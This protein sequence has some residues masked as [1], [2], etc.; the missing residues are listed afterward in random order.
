MRDK[1]KTIKISPNKLEDL[2]WMSYRYCIGRRTAAASMH[3]GTIADLIFNNLD[4]FNKER[5]E[6]IAEDIRRSIL[7]VIKWNKHIK[8]EDHYSVDNW[9]WDFYSALLLASQEC[10]YPR[11][12]IYHVDIASRN[13]TWYRDD[14]S[15]ND[16]YAESFDG[17]YHDLIPWVKLANALDESCHKDIT[18]N[19]EGQDSKYDNTIRCFSYAARTQ[20]EYTLVWASLDQDAGSNITMQG[21][22]I[23]EMITKI[24]NVK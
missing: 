10:P 8:V 18:V 2:I 23:P 13:V 14:S 3:A 19:V 11:E 4:I 22:V 12:A 1:K 5:R 17:M 6:V 16:K 7:D 24:E 9:S 20:A 15:V 21:Y